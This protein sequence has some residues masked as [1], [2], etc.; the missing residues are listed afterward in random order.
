EGRRVRDEVAVDHH[1]VEGLG[2]L[3]NRGPAPT[4]APLARRNRDRHT[5]AHFLR[6]FDHLAVLAK[7]ITLAQHAQGRLGPLTNFG[8]AGLQHTGAP[9]ISSG[10]GE[11]NTLHLALVKQKHVHRPFRPG[12]RL[13]HR[14]STLWM[15]AVSRGTRPIYAGREERVISSALPRS[16]QATRPRVAGGALPRCGRA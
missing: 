6:R 8:G 5:P 9:P 12:P 4:V 13:I 14:S 1:V 2:D 11:S 16:R 10:R 15:T 3:P 7:Q